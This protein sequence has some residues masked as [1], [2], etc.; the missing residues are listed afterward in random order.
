MK[1]IS[2]GVFIANRIVVEFPNLT[3]P[4]HPEFGLTEVSVLVS[5]GLHDDHGRIVISY[6]G[7]NTPYGDRKQIVCTAEELVELILA[8]QHLS[9]GH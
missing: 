8:N 9:K 5:E 7:E 2:Q 6:S 4:K 3:L 1:I